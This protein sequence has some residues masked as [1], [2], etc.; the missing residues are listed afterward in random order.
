MLRSCRQASPCRARLAV[1]TV[2]GWVAWPR[3]VC[4]LLAAG[5]RA[6]TPPQRV[7]LREL[8][9]RVRRAL[10]EATNVLKMVQN[11]LRQMSDAEAIKHVD[12]WQA[13]IKERCYGQA[14]P[15]QQQ[16]GH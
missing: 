7:G 10:Q 4:V 13:L 14:A 3:L 1:T 15:P 5:D 9:V 2:R 8:T 6:T 11:E 12:G 16:S